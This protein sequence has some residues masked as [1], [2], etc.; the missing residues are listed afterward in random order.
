MAIQYKTQPNK[1]QKQENKQ[2]N[3]DNMKSV[4]SA[5]AF[6][7]G[8]Y[9]LIA[10]AVVLIIV[11]VLNLLVGSLPANI[12]E[13]DFSYQDYYTLEESSIELTKNIETD[14]E[15]YVIAEAG[16]ED[17]MIMT[18][19][20]Q[21]KALNSRIHVQTK[22]TILYPN[23]AEDYTDDIVYPNSLVVES[24]NRYKYIDYYDIYVPD[25]TNYWT[26]G[27]YTVDFGGEN[28]ITSAL[29]YVASPTLPKIYWA[30]G[31]GEAEIPDNVVKAMENENFEL[32]EVNLLS[33]ES[34]PEDCDTLMIYSPANDL[35]EVEAEIILEYLENAGKLLLV[36]DYT[37]KDMPNLYAL[38]ENYGIQ[39]V[40]GLVFEGDGNMSIRNANYYLLPT[41]YYHEAT[42]PL[43][44]NGFKVL[45]PYA[46]G[47]LP[48]EQH[49]SSL[50]LTRL[51][52]TS[53][54]AYNK[55]NG[56]NVTTTE[57][58]EGDT[59]GEYTVAYAVTESVSAG[60]TQIMWYAT[61]AF[62]D[63]TNDG[64]V[65][66]ANMDM[67]LNSLGYLTNKESSISIHAKSLEMEYLTVPNQAASR[68]MILFVI[69]IPVAFLA[70]GVG[71]WIRRK[72]R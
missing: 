46:Q 39:A 16:K 4:F 52:T 63:E 40:D 15:I 70:T 67:F 19:L 20:D 62:L 27:T 8:S 17:N 6:K 1:Q 35:A 47:L 28:A 65:G 32:L 45:M 72:R 29:D 71:I 50:T 43:I 56:W 54:K 7:A 10:S 48:T 9:S 59:I 69:V 41:I 14:I 3:R 36:T 37:G 25:Y 38:M 23:F 26:D 66:G 21:Y 30:V 51:L 5:Q 68:L 13:V 24:E 11:V 33:A 31:H 2:K 18:L 61:S 55:A 34:V 44:N 42:I 53:D 22:D 12:T 64:W 60:D 58:E 49:R 57:W